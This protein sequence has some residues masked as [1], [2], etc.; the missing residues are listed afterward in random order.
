MPRNTAEESEYS[1]E[2]VVTYLYLEHLVM[3]GGTPNELIS[4]VSEDFGIPN[5]QVVHCFGMMV[6]SGFRF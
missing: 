2:E 1:N 4:K 5:K 3:R 6:L